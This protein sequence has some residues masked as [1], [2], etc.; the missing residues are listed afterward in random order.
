MVLGAS[1]RFPI[2][3]DGKTSLDTEGKFTFKFMPTADE[4]L[5]LNRVNQCII[6]TKLAWMSRMMVV[7]LDLVTGSLRS[8]SHP[9]R[10][11]CRLKISSS[12]WTKI[13]SFRFVGLT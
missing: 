9:L 1:G 8:A 6:A 7:K 2:D 10:R 11:L 3:C 13:R 12:L 5:T 4:N